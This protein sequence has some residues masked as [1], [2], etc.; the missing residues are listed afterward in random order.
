MGVDFPKGDTWREVVPNS[1]EAMPD[2][3]KYPPAPGV[4]LALSS[5]PAVHRLVHSEGVPRLGTL[6]GNRFPRKG[7]CG[8]RIPT[9]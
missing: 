9:G 4:P 5:E 8:Q 2:H 7:A 3:R 1:A 6:P